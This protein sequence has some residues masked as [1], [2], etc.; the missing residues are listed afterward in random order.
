MQKVSS[1]T[2]PDELAELVNVIERAG[3]ILKPATDRLLSPG[4]IRR[5]DGGDIRYIVP[6][7][8]TLHKTIYELL[9]KPNKVIHIAEFC[10][11]NCAGTLG[12]SIQIRPFYSVIL[13]HYVSK[14]GT[15]KS[16]GKR[17]E[18]Q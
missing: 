11:Y 17:R 9:P 18:K 15:G 6:Y 13:L 1:E 5:E 12:A 16:S 7:L 3:S 10:A 14:F 2:P 4:Q 8:K